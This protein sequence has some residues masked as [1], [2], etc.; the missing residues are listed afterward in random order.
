MEA[1]LTL[2]RP[3]NWQDFET[4]CKKLWGEIWNC[5][6][7]QKNGRLGQDQSGVDVFGIPF[8][9]DSYFGIQCKGKNEYIHSQFSEQEIL[10]EIE[11]AKEFAPP[12]K[13]FYLATTAVNDAKIQEFVRKINLEHRKK[14]F[15]EV[16]LFCWETI[17]DLIDENRQTHDW[18]VK[19]QNYKTKKSV[20]ITF[21]N[22]LT[23]ISS[24]PK[25]KRTITHY[26]Q[27]IVPAI[28]PLFAN[29]L[30]GLINQQNR[31]AEFSFVSTAYA[32]INLSYI[33]I[34]IVIHNTGDEPIEEYKVFL[35]FEGDI[36]D[37]SDTN[38]RN[39]SLINLVSKYNPNTYLWKESMSGKIIPKKSIL[40]GGDTL[41]SEDIFIKPF[42]KESEILIK[43][44]LISKDFKDNGEL[45][46]KVIPNID[47]AYKTFLVE[48]PL[49]VR[50][51]DGEIEDFE[52]PKDDK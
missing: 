42:P 52:V 17:V 51:D 5:P 35:E 19:N 29:P 14:G 6:E 24:T 27:K 8:N 47:I 32:T 20:A 34:E 48:D 39:N 36:Q 40:V 46:I 44:K 10:G 49:K 41:R 2:R 4:L 13:K 50:I 37:L 31:F 12:L 1:P 45:V 15:F 28:D 21:Q 3:S 26:K 23:E 18:Y 16:H 33:P 7:I 43:W 38:E 30:L 11:K 25:F 22:G 9:D